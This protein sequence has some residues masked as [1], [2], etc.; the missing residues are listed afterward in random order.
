MRDSLMPVTERGNAAHS[1]QPAI[2]WISWRTTSRV[3]AV[4]VL[5]LAIAGLSVRTLELLRNH[6]LF[7][8][9][10][11]VCM[12]ILDRSV[13]ALTKTLGYDQAAPFGFLLLQK[14]VFWIFGMS[15]GI[16]R[17][18]PFLF[19]LATVPLAILASKR[20]FQSKRQVVALVLSIGLICLNRDIAI[21]SAI[22][23]QY[24]L[25]CLI[26][27]VL[28]YIFAPSLSGAHEAAKN[29]RLSDALLTFSPFLV[30]FSYGSVF[31]LAG[32]GLALVL[33]AFA[34]P[35]RRFRLVTVYF[36]LSAVLNLATFFV[37][38]ARPALTNQWLVAWWKAAYMPLWPPGATFRWLSRTSVTFGESMTHTHLALLLP[39]ALV[40]TTV[41]AIWRRSW[42]WLACLASVS[43]CLGASALGKYPFAERLLL[44]L[45]PIMALIV[46]EAVDL[47]NRRW[48][49]ISVLAAVLILAGTGA[50]LT[51]GMQ[52]SKAIDS[53]RE[54]H[55]EMVA[56]FAPGD[57]LWVAPNS[58]PCF[59]YY[60]REYPLPV[61]ASVHFL[62]PSEIPAHLP[63]G[64]HWLLVI[65]YAKAA[66][67]GQKLLD[68]FTR[69]G[70]QRA[71][72][73]TEWTTARL[74]VVP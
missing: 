17:L 67:E 41:Y 57:D 33:R 31:I 15:D 34:T 53:V 38:S 63:S 43:A 72:F 30:W 23:K 11:S 8:D 68:D 50:R 26:T 2:G 28:V 71:S 21:Y 20:V 65:R 66:P 64:R 49:K 51:R 6:S 55:R 58:Q 48:P 74:I 24:S 5:L 42:F 46:A 62:R 12:D 52:N 45:Y 40:V 3:V 37:L 7:M 32:F 22:A 60:Q 47:L 70:Q 56:D 36:C 59:R 18:M 16:T 25:E 54:V 61:G 73:D 9:E 1:A 10:C 35:D 14:A 27:L 19:G 44:F 4:V 13:P 39:I 69:L 29:S